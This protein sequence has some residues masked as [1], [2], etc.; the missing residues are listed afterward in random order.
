MGHG[1]GDRCPDIWRWQGEERHPLRGDQRGRLSSVGCLGTNQATDWD[2]RTGKI[3]QKLAGHSAI[4]DSAAFSPDGRRIVT[5]SDD[6]T[7]IV[8]DSATGQAAHT[9]KGHSQPVNSAVLAQTD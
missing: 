7:A 5:G 3:I 2:N 8:W 6:S 4:V 1:E 9:L